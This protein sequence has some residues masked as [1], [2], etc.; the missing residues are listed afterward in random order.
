MDQKRTQDEF[1][2]Q[3]NALNKG[4]TVVGKYIGSSELVDIKCSNGHVWSVRP[5]NLFSHNSGCPYCA[6]K[7]VWIGYNDMW[8]TA[9]EM[10]SW[11]AYP[12][13]GFKYTK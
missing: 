4:F 13:D 7:A 12:E 1:I 8:T 6:N 3:V 5:T 9:P 11:L 10:A 2:E